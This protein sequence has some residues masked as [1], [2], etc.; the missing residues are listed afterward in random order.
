MRLPPPTVGGPYLWETPAWPDGLTWN[1]E[2]VTAALAAAH[3]AQGRLLAKAGLVGM[4]DRSALEAVAYEDDALGT[5][6]IEGEQLDRDSVRS[7]VARQ[8]GLDRAG[9]PASARHVDGLVAVLLDATRNAPAPVTLERLCGWQ[10]ALFPTGFSGPHRIAVG[11]LRTGTE[12]MRVVSGAWGQPVVHF[13]APPS[14][15][16]PGEMARFL[17][18][19]EAP[20]AAPADPFVRAGLA[21]LRLVT[22]HPF[23]DG[24][25]RITR[26]LTDLV[27][28]RA[29]T[30][31]TRLWSLS[32]QIEQ[33]RQDYYAALQSAQRGTGD[34]TTWLVW[35]LGAAARALGRAEAAVDRVLAKV[36]FWARHADFPCNARQRKILDRLLDAG[37]EGFIGGMTTR[38]AAALTGA[39]RATAQRDLAELVEAGML[40]P[41]PGGGR[42][43]AYRVQG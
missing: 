15:A 33:E 17:A 39:S 41:L 29:D 1:V 21:H 30:T 34:V 35:F 42:S 40:E 12:P 11:A 3:H 25:G 14:D 23:D 37:P 7:S 18:W 19:Q 4:A 13:E 43:A 16:L 2:P 32:A 28:A 6:R 27:L 8:L 36:R 22:L 24:N 5:A 20:A 26:A 10:A 31:P 9:A 38:K